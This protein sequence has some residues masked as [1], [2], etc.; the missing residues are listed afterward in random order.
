MARRGQNIYCRKDGRWE[1]RIKNPMG[2]KEKNRTAYIYVYGHSYEET[3]QKMDKIRLEMASNIIPCT[4]TFGKIAVL[5]FENVSQTAKESTCA[6]YNMKLQKHILPHFSSMRYEKI[7]PEDIRRFSDIKEKEGLSASYISDIILVI[8]SI[9]KF[10]RR[11]F[12]YINRLESIS[13]FKSDN[14]ESTEKKLLSDKEFGRLKSFLQS[15]PTPSNVG[16]LLAASTGIRLGE[17]CALKWGDIDHEKNFLTVRHTVQRISNV[18]GKGTRLVIAAPKSRNSRRVIPLPEFIIT[19]LK[20]EK[21]NNDCYLLSGTEK[22]AE[23]RTMQYRFKSILKKLSLP[24]VTF[25]AL[26]HMFATSC[27]ELGI[28]AKVLSSILGHSSVEL[29]LNRY[30][31]ATFDRKRDCIQKI[32]EKM[33]A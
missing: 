20:A 27:A 19:Y 16:I 13:R 9:A 3:R 32:S 22:I 25:H 1:G 2:R 7:T 30:V 15:E 21:K 26:R 6:N 24:Y 28:E 29:T 17:L 14:E 5:W 33:T 12:G 10:A 4:D 31:H 8:K 23:P 18:N 11:H